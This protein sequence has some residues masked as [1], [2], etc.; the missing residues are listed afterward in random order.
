MQVVTSAQ[1]RLYFNGGIGAMNYGGDLQEKKFTLKECNPSL[2][3]GATYYFSPNLLGNFNLTYGKI[4]ATDAKNG[5]KWIYRNLSFKSNIFEAAVTAE[6]DLFDIRESANPD[7]QNTEDQTIRYT[8]YIFAGM[9]LFNFNPYTYY[10]G[11]KVYLAPIKTEA[12][13]VPYSLW[14]VSVPFGIGI[15]YALTENIMIAAEMDIRKAFTDYVDDVSKFS[16]VDTTLLLNTNGQ[17]S[18]SLSYRADEIPNGH[19]AFYGERGNPDKKDKYY[20]FMIKVIFRF[21]EGTSLFK[22]GYGN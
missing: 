20:N 11:Q 1:S 17:L 5:L 7:F 6:Y 8:P 13:T 21:G 2:T 16:Y 9:A 12:E 19:Y 18:A 10:N 22:Y 14:Q 3:L 15:K 4:G